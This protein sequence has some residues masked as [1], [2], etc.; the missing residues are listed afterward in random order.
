[1]GRERLITMAAW[2]RRSEGSWFSTRFARALFGAG[3]LCHPQYMTITVSRQQRFG[4][5]TTS[6]PGLLPDSQT[7]GGHLY[8]ESR[9]IGD[10]SS[11]WIGSVPAIPAAT[12]SI[13]GRDRRRIRLRVAQVPDYQ[14]LPTQGIRA[15]AGRNQGPRTPSPRT[16]ATF[17]GE[18]RGAWLS[19]ARY[20]VQGRLPL[21]GS[22]DASPLHRKDRP[23]DA[24]STMWTLLFRLAQLRAY[25]R[26]ILGRRC[27][28]ADPAPHGRGPAGHDHSH[29]TCGAVWPMSAR[30]IQKRSVPHTRAG[31]LSS[32]YVEAF[33]T[34]VKAAVDWCVSNIFGRKRDRSPTN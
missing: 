15:C 10:G 8:R 3:G 14:W 23:Q 19:F 28:F 12:R 30:S 29:R 33:D 25:E 20:P 5:G 1:V 11:S 16:A 17:S 31:P 27:I 26:G 18:S 4:L 24:G 7:G 32:P 21:A 2:I 9:A 6:I 34:A 13:F 22:P